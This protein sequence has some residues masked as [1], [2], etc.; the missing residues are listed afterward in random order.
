M[1]RCMTG[2]AVAVASGAGIIGRVCHSAG[3]RRATIFTVAKVIQ[4]AALVSG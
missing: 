1:L 3:S 2:M 4:Q